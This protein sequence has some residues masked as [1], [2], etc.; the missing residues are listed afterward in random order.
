MLVAGFVEAEGYHQEGNGKQ[1]PVMI[2]E[3]DN[4][5]TLS[6]LIYLGD[7]F[8]RIEDGQ[9]AADNA[10]VEHIVLDFFVLGEEEEG[11]QSNVCTADIDEPAVT[12]HSG[13]I[14]AVRRNINLQEVE[15]QT[16]RQQGE[17]N[18]LLG[19]CALVP[20]QKIKTYCQCCAQ[21]D[22]EEIPAVKHCDDHN[23]ILL[24]LE[25]F[26]NPILAK[27]EG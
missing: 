1:H 26:D 9:Q 23:Y 2:V 18:D 15:D 7:G 19:G 3:A 25:E 5:Q 12:E 21:G 27:M 4:V 8:F 22:P 6:S 11:E 14:D 13:F 17:Q 10:D 20:Q 24:S 16:Q